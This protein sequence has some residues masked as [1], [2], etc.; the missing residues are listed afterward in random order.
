MNLSWGV[1]PA[2]PVEAEDNH[3]ERAERF[4]S[5][6]PLFAAGDIVVV[7]AGQPKRNQMQT[8]TNVVKVYEK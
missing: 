8:Q 4:V 5:E 7:T 1:V 2:A 3:Q 6:S